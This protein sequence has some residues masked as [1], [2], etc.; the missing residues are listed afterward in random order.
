[1]KTI[2]ESGLL[3]ISSLVLFNFLSFSSVVQAGL[4]FSLHEH[5]RREAGLWA[6]GG[7]QAA[8]HDLA[9]AAAPVWPCTSRCRGLPGT[10]PWSPCHPHE[11]VGPLSLWSAEETRLSAGVTCPAHS[12]PSSAHL[13]YLLC[14][15]RS[16]LRLSCHLYPAWERQ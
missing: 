8:M 3:I 5:L 14:D 2:S 11:E 15:T 9:R 1:M 7:H 10:C 6:T 4:A 12:R 13:V 16:G